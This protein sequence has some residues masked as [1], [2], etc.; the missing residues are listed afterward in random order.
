MKVDLSS[1]EEF[2]NCKYDHAYWIFPCNYSN[3]YWAM[4]D[5]E[6]QQPTKEIAITA[7]VKLEEAMA[8]SEERGR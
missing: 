6:W 1:P 4:E 5:D 8:D 7:T 2:V 3:S